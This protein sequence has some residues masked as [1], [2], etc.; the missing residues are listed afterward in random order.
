MR[1]NQRQSPFAGVAYS[2]G[3]LLIVFSVGR[4]LLAGIVASVPEIDAGSVSAG[5]GLLAGGLLI[6]R[7]RRR[8]K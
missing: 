3:L 1:F 2:L 6:L 8:S 7:A 5:L 4:N